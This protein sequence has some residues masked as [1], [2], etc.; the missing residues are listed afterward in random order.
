LIKHS[1]DLCAKRETEGKNRNMNM[2]FSIVWAIIC[3]VALFSSG[4]FAQGKNGTTLAAYKTLDVCSMNETTW[5]YSGVVSVWN[6]GAV[7]TVGFLLNDWIQNQVVGPTW[8]NRYNPIASSGGLI[9]KGTNLGTAT[10]F[11][12]S[13]EGAPLPGTIRNVASI[14]ILNHSGSLGTAKG[15]EPKATWLGGAPPPCSIG[16]G[17]TYTIGY[18]G[19]KPD[20]V[21]RGSYSRSAVF[22]LSGKTWNEVINDTGGSGY[23]ILAVQYIA[24]LLNIANGASVPSGVQ[25]TINLATAWFN[26]NSPTACPKGNSCG[27]QKDWGAILA[28]YNQGIYPGGPSHCDE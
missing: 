17:C 15:P 16:D 10:T 6:E 9:P 2:N 5:Q 20:V 8:T 14:T 13:V 27:D 18:W 28:L 3:I 11:S 19:K 24:A 7:D 23:N 26:A 21:W 12:Y 4:A 1:N 25:T 22:Y